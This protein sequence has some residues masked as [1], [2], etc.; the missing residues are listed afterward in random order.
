MAVVRARS[1]PPYGLFAAAAFAVIA[2]GAAVIFYVMWSKSLAD[3][4]S[5]LTDK[6]TLN[7]S[8]EQLNAQI[9]TLN[10]DLTKFRSTNSQLTSDRDGRKNEAERLLKQYQDLSQALQRRESTLTSVQDSFRDKTTTYQSDLNKI[11]DQ[12][13]VLLA[14]R[15]QAVTSGESKLNDAI[16]KADDERRHLVLQID[17][18]QGQVARQ[19]AE[20]RQLRERIINQGGVKTD[21]TVGEADGRVIRAAG[22]T[23]SVYISL[24]KKDRV[25]P[26]MTFTV[27]DPRLG[28]R[29]TDDDTA[30]G[31]GSIEVIEVKDDSAICRIT[32]TTK[33]RAIQTNDL[34]ANLVYHNERDR[35]F[36]FVVFGNF[37]LDGDG[38]FTTTERDRL[39]TL[40]QAWGGQVDD[41]VTAQTD[42][43]VLGDKPQIPPTSILTTEP[44]TE[45]APTNV[46]PGGIIDTRTKEQAKYEELII[47]A[48]RLAIPVL[49]QNRFLFMIGYYNTTVV[50]Y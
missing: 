15:D 48:R 9:K 21:V 40:I 17:D 16:Q 14:A 4:D 31:N 30:M 26:G 18:L 39:I 41:D 46:E 44:A 5:A 11:G 3:R 35:K 47:S 19:S 22:T 13:T 28:V 42:F 45:P 43:L 49:N 24:G 25:M 12:I 7:K 23:G 6:T 2:I 29:W 20:I 34:I 50:R 1:S 38:V 36:R 32:R 8:N 37:D 10:D 27:Y 33:N